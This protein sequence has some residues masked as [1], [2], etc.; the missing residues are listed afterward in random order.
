MKGIRK[1]D[2]ISWIH[3]GKVFQYNMDQRISHIIASTFFV[4]INN[5]IFSIRGVVMLNKMNDFR[6]PGQRV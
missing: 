1:V 6:F 5:C 3:A 4:F 2:M